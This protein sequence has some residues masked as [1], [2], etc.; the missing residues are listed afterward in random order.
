MSK[1]E[2]LD[3]FPQVNPIQ[4]KLN[5]YEYLMGSTGLGLMKLSYNPYIN[6][7]I[8][9]SGLHLVAAWDPEPERINPRP[10]SP[11]NK[12]NTSIPNWR[13]ALMLMDLSWQM[14]SIAYM[15]CS[16]SEECNAR[17]N[18]WKTTCKRN[19]EYTVD[20]MVATKRINNYTNISSYD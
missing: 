12:T 4:Y 18:F 14:K 11:C 5:I 8:F 17:D 10:A 13:E 1:R 6:F 20:L 16:S 19:Q 9:P 2:K 15:L 3:L 7:H